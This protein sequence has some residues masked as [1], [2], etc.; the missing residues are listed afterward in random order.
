M[1]S[2]EFYF[3]FFPAL[4]VESASGHICEER[5]E[6]VSGEK[7]KV[8]EKKKDKVKFEFHRRDTFLLFT[9]ICGVCLHYKI[10]GAFQMPILVPDRF[11]LHHLIAH[12]PL[13]TVKK[14]RRKRRRR[15]RRKRKI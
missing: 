8:K 6:G 5:T 4:P 7:K 2:I 14:T 15:K 13:L 11:H 12:L 10:S 1:E 9:Y 3:L